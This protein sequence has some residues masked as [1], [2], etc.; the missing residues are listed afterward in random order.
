MGSCSTVFSSK[1][2][3][4]KVDIYLVVRAQLLDLLS[5]VD[6]T[7]SLCKPCSSC[8]TTF[9][10]KTHNPY[11][12]DETNKVLCSIMHSKAGLSLTL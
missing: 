8:R 7:W 3:V 9:V 10:V 6:D 5:S 11:K 12:P 1:V 4:D 2:A